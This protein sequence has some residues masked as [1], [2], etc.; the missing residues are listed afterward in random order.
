[1]RS[2]LGLS[3]V[4]PLV[5][6][7]QIAPMEASRAA[8]SQEQ[9]RVCETAEEATQGN[10][11]IPESQES[12]KPRPG[13]AALDHLAA[14]TGFSAVPATGSPPALLGACQ[15]SDSSVRQRICMMPLLLVRLPGG[16]PA[17]WKR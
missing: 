4:L 7:N 1:M 12:T 9:M 10:T 13:P 3:L 14:E 2:V 8:S 15:S 17:T 11:S 5:T 6:P 16:T